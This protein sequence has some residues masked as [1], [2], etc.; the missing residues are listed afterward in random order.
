MQSNLIVR[1]RVSMSTSRAGLLL[2]RLRFLLRGDDGMS[3]AEY[4]IGTL[5]AAA[6]GAILYTAVNSDTIKGAVTA[7]LE[8][9]FAG[10]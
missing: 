2:R 4:A 10:I 8:R 5:A 6:L 9:G 1:S 7:L 3:T